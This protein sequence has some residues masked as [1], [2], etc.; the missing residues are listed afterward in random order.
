LVLSVRTVEGHIFRAMARTG[1]ANRDELG[2]MLT[3]RE[4]DT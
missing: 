4:T 2:R 3:R 1:A